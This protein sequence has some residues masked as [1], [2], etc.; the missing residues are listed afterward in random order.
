[1]LNKVG[2]ASLVLFLISTFKTLPFAY[3]IRFYL[4]VFKYIV[5]QKPMFN[6]IRVNT[7]GVNSPKEVFRWIDYDTY[8]SPLEIDMFLHKS[9]STYF[10]DLDIARTKMV[11]I[12]FQ[13]LFCNYYDNVSGEFRGKSLKN[14]PFIPVAT[15]QSTF[16]HELTVFQ[17]FTIKSRV[18][19]WDGKWLFILSKFVTKKNGNERVNCISVTKYVFK[20]K[21]RI[22]II[23]Q[24]MLKEC[25][26]W[27]E[28]VEAES[29]KNLKL[30]SQMRDVSELEIIE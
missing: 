22:T 13:T 5:L 24:E 4:K 12:I 11:C 23:P 15:V 29:Q 3:V 30:I 17:R 25:G 6:K 2:K 16:K 7:F 18:L 1:M 21:G 19:S 8:V 28:E 26:L 9:N 10:A 20:K 27:N 14:L